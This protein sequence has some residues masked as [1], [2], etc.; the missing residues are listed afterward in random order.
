MLHP[1]RVRGLVGTIPVVPRVE[2][3]AMTYDPLG[4]R[5]P[6]RGSTCKPG[7]KPRDK[8]EYPIT[9]KEYPVFKYRLKPHYLHARNAKDTKK[10]G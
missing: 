4:V 3:G 10:N 1:L 6:Q 7:V 5:E 9:N 8:S 2:P